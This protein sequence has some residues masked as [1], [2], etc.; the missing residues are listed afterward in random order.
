MVLPWRF[1]FNRNVHLHKAAQSVTYLHSDSEFPFNYFNV[2]KWKR[3]ITG[4]FEIIIW[5]FPSSSRIWTHLSAW[6][7]RI[8][9]CCLLMCCWEKAFDRCFHFRSKIWA[10]EPDSQICL[11][12]LLLNIRELFVTV[13]SCGKSVFS[14]RLH[15]QCSRCVAQRAALIGETD[16]KLQQYLQKSQSDAPMLHWMLY[17]LL[18]KKI[19]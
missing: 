7:V 1:G 14:S 8:V 6:F 13:F 10:A 19:K 16:R 4:W 12:L 11:L 9:A 17:W 2:W 18:F 3:T 15:L 5:N